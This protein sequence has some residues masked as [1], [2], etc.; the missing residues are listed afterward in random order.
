M[1]VDTGEFIRVRSSR[2]R[3]TYEDSRT[4]L[5]ASELSDWPSIVEVERMQLQ[6]MAQIMGHDSLNNTMVYV[7]ELGEP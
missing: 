3:L 5:N 7:R 2:K 1:Q 6:R 4:I